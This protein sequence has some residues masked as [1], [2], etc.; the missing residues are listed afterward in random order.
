LITDKDGSM[1]TSKSPERLVF[2]S[3]AVVAIAMTLLVLPLAEVVPELVA[4]HGESID[5]I[6]R[7]QWQIYSFLLSFAVIARQWISHHQLF[8][9]IKAYS[10]PLMAVN[11]CWLLTIAVLPFPTEMIGGFGTDHFTTMFYIGTILASSICQMVMMLIVRR[12]QSVAKSPDAISD[13]RLVN[14]IG[15]TVALA[16]ALLLVA[17]VPAVSYFAI[18]LLLVPSVLTRVRYRRAPTQAA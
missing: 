17:L 12:D 2:F 6:T 16:A 5:A 14:T 1:D 18:L 11:L 3:D 8:E 13:R 7:H 15:S 4:E 10:R 9:Q